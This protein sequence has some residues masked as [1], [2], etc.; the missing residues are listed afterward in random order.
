ML[1]EWQEGGEDGATWEDELTIKDQC[2]DFN[3]ENKVELLRMI[4]IGSEECTKE[5]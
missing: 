5:E 4:M 1:K 2:P 3:L